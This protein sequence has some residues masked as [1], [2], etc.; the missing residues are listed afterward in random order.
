MS[1]KDKAKSKVKNKMKKVAFKVIKPFLP[2]IIIIVGL[3]FAIC[4]IIDA[5]FVQE[6][7]TDSSSMPEAQ[8]EL[9]TKCIE[10]AEYLNTCHNYKDGE[11]TQYLLDLD[12]RETD[13][14]VQWSHLYS[15]MAFHN[16]TDNAK[17]D[18]ALLNK[19][20]SEFESTFI[21]EKITV[22]VETTTKDDK[23]NTSTSTNEETAYILVESDTIMGHYKYH[24][25]EK[26]IENGNTKT[27]K[28]VFTNEEIIGEKYERLKNYLKDKL[29]IR[30]SD[31]DT[32]VEVVIQ[33]AN[34][35]YE[36]EENTSWLQG[37]SSS[38]TIITDGKGLIPT[39]YVHLAYT[40]LYEYNF[41]F[42]YENSS[43]NAVLINYILGTDVRSTYSVQILWL[44][45]MEQ[46]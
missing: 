24:Y 33:A 10:K 22:K 44:W 38:S 43:N 20:A 8:Q 2:F 29:R 32:D 42:W 11:S 45:Q 4:T 28:K 31:I 40:W 3:F 19:V 17:I 37:S 26:T 18:E 36:G 39:R 25:E 27:T 6:V 41:S 34:G 21:Y 12:S 23:G 16:M 1:I 15:I 46:L 14:E 35:Y 7:Q 9:R 5:V 13:K 30:E